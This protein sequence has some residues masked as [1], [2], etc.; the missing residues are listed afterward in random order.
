MTTPTARSSVRLL[1]EDPD[2]GVG[3]APADV[4]A[5]LE[6]SS[7]RVGSVAAG[8]WRPADQKHEPG[9]FGL[10]L[11]DGILVRAVTVG[12]RTCAEMIGP[13]DIVRPWVQSMS[14]AGSIESTVEWTAVSET[15]MAVLDGA[16]V[17]RM[18]EHPEVLSAL[19]DR[20]MLR[21]HWLA[22]H[23]AVCH[24]RRVDERLLLVLWHFAYRWGRVTSSGTVLPLPLTHALLAKVVGAQRPTVSTALADLQREGV[25]SRGEERSWVLHGEAPESLADVR[26]RPIGQGRIALDELAD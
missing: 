1:D 4:R 15:S 3:I 7:V 23:L 24:M 10:F 21:T 19:G 8:P 14:G 26:E 6:R 17:H 9:A 5:A 20:V 18:A 12:E 2:L 25:L 16:F 22:F 13:G 11:L